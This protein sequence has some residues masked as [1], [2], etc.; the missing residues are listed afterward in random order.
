[1]RQVP[2]WASATA[3]SAGKGQWGSQTSEIERER[4]H[5]NGHE[6]KG[7]SAVRCCLAKPSPALEAAAR[8]LQGLKTLRP[9]LL[10]RSTTP[11]LYL[12]AHLQPTIPCPT[13]TTAHLPTITMATEVRN[14][15]A[16][17]FPAIIGG[18][19]PLVCVAINMLT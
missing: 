4:S 3:R 1:V 5:V 8:F 18:R 15:P 10:T 2:R 6:R 13:T 12:S 17:P 19:M 14:A 16:A 7:A 11:A 9:Q